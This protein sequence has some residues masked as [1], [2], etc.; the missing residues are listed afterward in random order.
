VTAARKLEE[1]EP[2]DLSE[3]EAR[4]QKVIESEYHPEP[5][6]FDDFDLWED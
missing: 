3:L 4:R 5:P 1:V 2:M 6:P